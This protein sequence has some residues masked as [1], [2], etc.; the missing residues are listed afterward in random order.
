M[1]EQDVQQ[2]MQRVEHAPAEMHGHVH[3]FDSAYERIVQM[4]TN[5]GGAQSEA[6]H[7]DMASLNAKL[8]DK[9]LLSNLEIVGVDQ[10][11]HLIT[12]DMADNHTV[13]QDAS[14]VNDFG[15][16][17]SGRGEAEAAATAAML[18]LNVTRNPDRAYNVPDPL[19]NPEEAAAG[20][21]K[22]VFN[23]LMGGDQQGAAPLGMNPLMWKAWTGSPS[24]PEPEP[25][26]EPEPPQADA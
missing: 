3:N 25:Q 4:Q 18:G 7:R 23:G 17:G 1:S 21:I 22:T 8:H 11:H 6:F 2:V 15:A 16:L 24:A 14:H 19:G 26:P 9:G 12:R 20:I 13:T 5:D 10:D